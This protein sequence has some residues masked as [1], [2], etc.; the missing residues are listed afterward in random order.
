MY[1]GAGG[2]DLFDEYMEM[3]GGLLRQYAGKKVMRILKHM[4]PKRSRTGRWYR[5][6]RI[7]GAP[8]ILEQIPEGHNTY[9]PYQMIDFDKL[10]KDFFYGQEKVSS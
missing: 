9:K 5:T 6:I 1:T 4:Y 8:G 10:V 7:S 3:Y 2:A